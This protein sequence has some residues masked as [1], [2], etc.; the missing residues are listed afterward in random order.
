MKN[1]VPDPRLHS[2]VEGIVRIASGDLST[3]IP[4]SGARDDVAAVIAGINLMADDLQTIYQEL[5]E[6]VESRTA[7]LRQAQVELERM[8]LTDPLTQ[9]ANRTALNSVLSHALAETSRGEMPPALLILDLDSFKGINDTLG[10]SAGDDVLRVIARRLQDAVRVTDTVAR[11]GGDE[12]AVMLPKSNL[13][14]AR[15]VAN[16]ILKALSESLEIGDLRITCGTSIG[17]RVAEP[18]QSVDDLVMEADTAMYAAKAQPHSGIK[19]FEPA[20]L[21]ARRLQ[22]LMVTE[23]REAIQ[24]DQ[25]TLHYQP[26]VELAT[27]RIEGVEA[28][29]RWNHPERGLLMPDQFIPLAEETGMIVELG[30]WVL[31]AAVRQ[32]RDWQDRLPLDDAFSVRVNISTTELQNLEL[33]EHVQ[34]ILRETGVDAA[35]LIIE[36]TESMAVTGGDVDKYSLSGLRQL[37][38]QLEIDDFGTGYSSISYLRKLPVNVVKIDRSLID[39]LGTDAEQGGFVEA[40][41]HLIHACGLTAVAEGIETAEQ[42]DELVRLGC[43]SGQGYYFGRPVPAADLEELI[44]LGRSVAQ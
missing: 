44:S 15:R 5:E 21:Y 6:R 12:F 26:V 36:L 38:V 4:H 17:V 34:D 28:L 27:G 14:R 40:V 31:R 22:S 37:G 19:I 33:I 1:D 11:L 39:G 35:N 25:L 29:V 43:A 9:L 18:G 7:M 23:M 2:L 13:V 20:L 30:H 32:L 10:H 24:Q 42:A 16:R 8:A 3:R 41:L